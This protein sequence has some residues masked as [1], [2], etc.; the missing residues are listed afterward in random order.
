MKKETYEKPEVTDEATFEARSGAYDMLPQ[1][2]YNS[3]D[4]GGKCG[5]LCGYGNGDSGNPI[6]YTGR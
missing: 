6:P 1:N 4:P 3:I 5:K 2:T